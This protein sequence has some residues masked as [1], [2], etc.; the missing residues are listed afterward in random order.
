MRKNILIDQYSDEEFTRIVN[1]SYSMKEVVKKLG[2]TSHNGRNSDVVKKR[3][4]KQGLSTNHFEYKKGIDRTVDNVFCENST[5]SQATLRRW[6]YSGNYSEYKC[7]ICGQFPIWFG[8]PLSLTLDH[9]NGNNH[10]NRIENLRWICPNCDRTLDTFAGK[11]VKHI[12]KKYFCID[13]GKEISNGA[14]RCNSCNG[15]LHHRSVKDNLSRDELKDL[16][17]NNTFTKIA[18]MYC[19]S[20]NAVKKWC[21]KFDLPF[22]TT[23]IK[24]ISDENWV[25]V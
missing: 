21:K 15:K 24:N 16:I 14:K 8:K 9:I 20:A 23:D 19:V 17:R 25:Y 11:N 5:A 13:C 2:Y 22:R 4:I 6:Y 12:H 10:D 7:A 1:T 18:D 3:I